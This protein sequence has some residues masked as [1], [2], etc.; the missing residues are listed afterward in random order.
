[1]IHFIPCGVKP[2]TNLPLNLSMGGKETGEK[3][4]LKGNKR[5][6]RRVKI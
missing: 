5:R 2:Q 6:K 1:M 4:K 3:N